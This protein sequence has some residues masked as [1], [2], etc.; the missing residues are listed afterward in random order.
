MRVIGGYGYSLFRW[1]PRKP[2]CFWLTARRHELAG[3]G[4]YLREGC[5]LTPART[6]RQLGPSRIARAFQG[7]RLRVSA[8]DARLVNCAKGAPRGT[9]YR[10]GGTPSRPRR[11]LRGTPGP[12]WRSALVTALDAGKRATCGRPVAAPAR[13]ASCGTPEAKPE[14]K[15]R[16]AARAALAGLDHKP[17][18]LRRTAV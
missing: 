3:N 9:C 15:A 4:Q 11:G 1:A 13:P 7:V 8:W 16:W 5:S 12:R 17:T 6:T 14:R 18:P 2:L 10:S